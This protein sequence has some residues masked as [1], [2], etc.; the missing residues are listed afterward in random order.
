MGHG[1]LCPA[2]SG[3]VPDKAITFAGKKKR[4]GYLGIL[5]SQFQNGTF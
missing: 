3:I 1:E 4:N 5:L 2:N